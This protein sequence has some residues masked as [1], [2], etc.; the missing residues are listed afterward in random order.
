MINLKNYHWNLESTWKSSRLMRSKNST[1]VS[2]VSKYKT[3]SK[4]K[5]LKSFIRSFVGKN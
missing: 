3:I 4:Y 1:M 2:I 5:A